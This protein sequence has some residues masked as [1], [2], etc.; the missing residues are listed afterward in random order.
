MTLLNDAGP[1]WRYQPRRESKPFDKPESID[2]EP[3]LGG[4]A[5]ST[6]PTRKRYAFLRS[7]KLGAT[8]EESGRLCRM[9]PSG[10]TVF[11]PE[12]FG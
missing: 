6:P 10:V 3:V 2:T 1:L 5:P 7:K 4:G 12:C 8:W 9:G 11:K